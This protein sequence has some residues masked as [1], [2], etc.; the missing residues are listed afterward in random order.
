MEIKYPHFNR[1]WPALKNDWVFISLVMFILVSL[2]LGYKAYFTDPKNCNDVRILGR[3][4]WQ[5]KYDK[6]PKHYS[7]LSRKVDGVQN[8]II[9]ESLI[10]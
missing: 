10:K 3:E 5:N 1:V 2:S 7:Y 8:H 4:Y 9:C 6:N